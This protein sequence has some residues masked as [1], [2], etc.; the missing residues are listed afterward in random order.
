MADFAVWATAAEEAFGWP[1]GTALKAYA[2]NRAE[3]V[4]LGIES[5]AVAFTVCELLKHKPDGFEGTMTELLDELEDH[6]SEKMRNAK[7]WPGSARSLSNRLRRSSTALRQVGINVD[8][9]RRAGDKKGTR[10]VRID[11]THKVASDT[12]DASDVAPKGDNNGVSASDA[13]SDANPS[14]QTYLR[15]IHR[16]TGKAL[17]CAVYKVCLTQLTHLTQENTHY[18][19]RRG[20]RLRRCSSYDTH[21]VADGV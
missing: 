14:S 1:E 20:I 15:Q 7:T 6:A 5:D 19:P 8:L 16:Q 11:S 9:D 12:S 3:A 13:T 18:L 10:L 17:R 2:E 21:A 4:E